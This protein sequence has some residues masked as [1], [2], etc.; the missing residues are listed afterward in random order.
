MTTCDETEKNPDGLI[1]AGVSFIYRMFEEEGRE[2][3]KLAHLSRFC[4]G[5]RCTRRH[6]HCVENRAAS[7][8]TEL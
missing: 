4:A 6:G 7:I 8:E 2:L 3:F 1:D 5:N